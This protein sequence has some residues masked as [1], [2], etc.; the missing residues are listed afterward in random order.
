MA[1]RDKRIAA[2]RL[3]PKNVR[4]DELDAVLQGVGFEV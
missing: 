4:P 3:N 1:K 2:M